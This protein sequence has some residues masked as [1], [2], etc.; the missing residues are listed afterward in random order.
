MAANID[1]QVF[2]DTLTILSTYN[3]ELTAI[4][5]LDQPKEV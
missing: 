3:I 4:V 1:I 5:K 2:R